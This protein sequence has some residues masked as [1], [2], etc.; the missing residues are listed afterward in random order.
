MEDTQN[1]H[2]LQRIQSQLTSILFKD[3]LILFLNWGDSILHPFFKVL[4]SF[5]QCYILFIVIVV[6]CP[7]IG[8]PRKSIHL[9]ICGTDR[10]HHQLIEMMEIN[11]MQFIQINV[12]NDNDL[13]TGAN[14]RSLQG[15]YDYCSGE[16]WAISTDWKL[17]I[18]WFTIC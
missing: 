16:I 10:A 17:A 2:R 7:G 18:K 14:K 3:N 8:F 15:N 12:C 5:P 11:N 4:S 9:N 13:M 1:S 6:P